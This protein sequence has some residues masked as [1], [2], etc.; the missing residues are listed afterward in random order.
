VSL[1][2]AL[3]ELDFGPCYH[4]IELMNHP[5][6]VPLWE[7]ATRGEPVHWEKIFGGYRATVDWPS[8]ASSRLVLFVLRSSLAE[9][10][11]E[12]HPN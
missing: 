8:A 3:E 7:A 11:P 4:M 2:V 10:K 1:K 9:V 6:H 5:E 12:H